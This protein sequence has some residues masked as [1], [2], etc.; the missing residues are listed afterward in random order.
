[1]VLVGSRETWTAVY[2]LSVQEGASDQEPEG[3]S[4]HTGQGYVAGGT[5]QNPPG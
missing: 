4:W 2:R 3:K 1:M 5:L